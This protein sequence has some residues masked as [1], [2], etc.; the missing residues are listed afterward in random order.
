MHD[1]DLPRPTEVNAS[2]ASQGDKK[3]KVPLSVPCVRVL[4]VLAKLT[5]PAT[6]REVAEMC[7]EHRRASDWARGLL[8]YLRRLGFAETT[9]GV[10]AFNAA[11][12]RIT[13]AGRARLGIG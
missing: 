6:A 9:G 11:C 4:R 7:G 8:V 3:R 5:C 13:D 10:G 12:W 2:T 1:N